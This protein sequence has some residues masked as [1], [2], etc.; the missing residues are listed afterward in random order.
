MLTATEDMPPSLRQDFNPHLLELF[1]PS[2]QSFFALRL[3]LS[4]PG[5]QLGIVPFAGRDLTF[6]ILPETGKGVDPRRNSWG[7]AT[8]CARKITGWHE[9]RKMFI[10]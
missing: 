4:F 7:N 5:L 6:W 1:F 2:L 3:F 9:Y 10:L 8:E